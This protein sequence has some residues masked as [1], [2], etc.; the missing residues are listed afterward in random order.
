MIHPSWVALHSMAHSFIELDKPVVSVQHSDSWILEVLPHLELFFNTDYIPHVVQLFFVAYLFYTWY[1]YL[2][3]AHRYS[4]PLSSPHWQPLICSLYLWICCFFVTFTSLLC[5]WDS[6]YKWYYSVFVFFWFI[7]LST[8]PSKSTLHTH[9]HI[10]IHTH[11]YHIFFIHLSADGHL[12]YFH[13]LSIANNAG[14]HVFFFNRDI[15]FC[16]FFRYILR[17]RTAGSYGSY[18]FSI[19]RNIY[20]VSCS[21]CCKLHFHQQWER[22]PFSPYPHQNLLFAYPSLCFV[23]FFLTLLFS[24]D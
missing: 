24:D 21:V 6:T 3:I 1:L 11:I 2:L 12:G 8:I 9:T 23:F 19:L 16:L 18:I 4:S 7:S 22:V 20:T 10:Y 14:V 17:S 15:F 13:I 5:Y